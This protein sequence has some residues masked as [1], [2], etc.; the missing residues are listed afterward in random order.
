M[1]DERMLLR[2]I[3]SRKTLNSFVILMMI[4]ITNLFIVDYKSNVR[5]WAYDVSYII[6]LLSDNSKQAWFVLMFI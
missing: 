1:K 2:I 4:F 6:L 5:M 3:L